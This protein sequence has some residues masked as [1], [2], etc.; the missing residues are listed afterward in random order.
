MPPDQRVDPAKVQVLLEDFFPEEPLMLSA[1]RMHTLVAELVQRG[2]SGGAVYDGL[3][4][5]T[6]AEFGA[7]LVTLDQRAERTYRQCGVNYRMLA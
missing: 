2:V 1:A 5:L 3:I 7:E 4:A 6:A